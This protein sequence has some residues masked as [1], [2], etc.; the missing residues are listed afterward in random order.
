[1]DKKITQKQETVSFSPGRSPRELQEQQAIRK[2]GGNIRYESLLKRKTRFTP[3]D[4]PKL[5]AS[6]TRRFTR[7]KKATTQEKK[8]IQNA[9]TRDLVGKFFKNVISKRNELIRLLK[10]RNFRKKIAELNLIEKGQY[11]GELEMDDVAQLFPTI[12]EHFSEENKQKVLES[13][14][15][16]LFE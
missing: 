4:I 15:R 3:R 5:A 16:V 1:L 2:C 12:W 14:E 13:V 6:Y 9:F 10:R 8:I 11:A 7:G